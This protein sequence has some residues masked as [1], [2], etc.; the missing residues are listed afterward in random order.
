MRCAERGIWRI[1]SRR[2][3]ISCEV[4]VDKEETGLELELG[5]GALVWRKRRKVI[6]RM[7]VAFWLLVAVFVIWVF[8]EPRIL[9]TTRITIK[10]KDIPKEFDGFKIVHLSDIHHGSNFHLD[11]VKKVVDKT[12]ALEPDLILIIGDYITENKK[13]I[14][15]CFEVVKELKS[16]Y[17]IISV[18]G[19]HDY[20]T[21]SDLVR[22]GMKRAG[23]EDME[24]RSTWI[25]KE[26]ARIKVGGVGDFWEAEQKL[27]ATV[28]DVNK[29]DFVILLSHNPDYA[30]KV[31]DE[32]ID[33]MLC[34]H[35]HGGQVTIFGLYAPVLPIRYGQ[36]YR[37]GVVEKGTMKIIISRG[38][39]LISPAV[40]FFCPPQIILIT[41]KNES[42]E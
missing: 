9:L 29:N 2:L 1:Q 12:N 21:D 30:E 19:N 37:S 13:Y 41:L 24:N 16:K 25:S 33:L 39:G 7:L 31:S 18:L 38:I 40:R 42:E 34:G 26:G 6:E 20:W 35:T 4:D 36:K 32:L 11:S 23:I 10:D 14:L 17:G 3:K 15:P 28:S 8:V 22:D 27:D 5:E